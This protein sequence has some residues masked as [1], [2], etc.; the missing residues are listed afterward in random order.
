[1]KIS[2]WKP[3]DKYFFNLNISIT[4]S[5]SFSYYRLTNFRAKTQFEVNEGQNLSAWTIE[6]PADLNVAQDENDIIFKAL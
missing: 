3:Y 6:R 4:S 1:M 2:Q 5:T